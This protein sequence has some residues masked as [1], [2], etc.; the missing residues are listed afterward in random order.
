MGL[1]RV[2]WAYIGLY[3]LI[4]DYMVVFQNQGYLAGATSNEDYSIFAFI[5]GPPTSAKYH[6]GL[7]WD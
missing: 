2:I 5:L 4:E 3:R 6:V 1:N 7:C